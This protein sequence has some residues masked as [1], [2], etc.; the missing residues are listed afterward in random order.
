LRCKSGAEG[1]STATTGGKA[2][3]DSSRVRA[4]A[5]AAA[6]AAAPTVAARVSSVSTVPAAV[7]AAVPVVSSI[8][9]SMGRDATRAI[10]LK[11][12]ATRFPPP[13]PSEAMHT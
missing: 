4:A 11:G 1:A 2:L 9:G 10:V 5:A 13:S 7:A 3:I 8:E 6:A 12:T